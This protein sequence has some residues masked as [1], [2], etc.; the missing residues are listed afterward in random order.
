[1]KRSDCLPGNPEACGACFTCSLSKDAMRWSR[2]FDTGLRQAQ[3]LL[4]M[5]GEGSYFT[6]DTLA[7][8]LAGRILDDPD[9]AHRR[10][11]PVENVQLS[12]R[13]RPEAGKGADRLQ[14]REAA[15]D[16]RHRAE[17]AEL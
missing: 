5:S 4:R 6:H 10:H 9:R 8:P 11:E 2:S 13:V 17:H 15:G 16:P 1:M 12:G 3:S 7:A 14:R